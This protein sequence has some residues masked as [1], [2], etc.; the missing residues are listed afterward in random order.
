VVT[1]ISRFDDEAKAIALQADGKIVV[2]GSA[3]ADFVVVRYD[4]PGL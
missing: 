1:P 4:K 3:D 2:A